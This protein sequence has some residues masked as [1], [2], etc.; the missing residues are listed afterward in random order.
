[1]FSLIIFACMFVCMPGS[2]GGTDLFRYLHIFSVLLYISLSFPSRT[3]RF[4]IRVCY[5]NVCSAPIT[6]IISLH[7]LVVISLYIFICIYLTHAHTHTRLLHRLLLL[8]DI[9]RFSYQPEAHTHNQSCTLSLT[10]SPQSLQRYC[11]S[12]HTRLTH[13]ILVSLS[14]SVSNA[15][16]QLPQQ[17][18]L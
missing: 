8:G 18:L 3:S 10:H 15:H 13:N 16:I 7:L 12:F 11:Y 4:S 5:S 2:Q 9:R 6:H 1:M 14:L 17:S